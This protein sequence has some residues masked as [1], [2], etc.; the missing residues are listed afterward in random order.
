MIDLPY[1]TCK[2]AIFSTHRNAGRLRERLVELLVDQPW[3]QVVDPQ[4]VRGFVSGEIVLALCDREAD[5]EWPWLERLANV[6]E[7]LPLPP[8]LWEEDFTILA[9]WCLQFGKCHVERMSLRR[10]TSQFECRIKA[11]SG[12]MHM[13]DLLEEA[14]ERLREQTVTD[15]LTGIPNR[16]RFEEQFDYMWG[17]AV[18]ERIPIA[19]ILSDI[20]CFKN[21]NDRLGHQEGDRCLQAVATRL[22]DIV[23]GAEDLVARFG[24]EEFVVLLW[25][26]D[27]TKAGETAEKLRLGVRDLAIAHPGYGAGRVTISLGVACATP[28]LESSAEAFLFHADKLLYEAKAGGRDRWVQRPLVPPA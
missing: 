26:A 8:N 28:V 9:R 2:V 5:T 20:D 27:P 21:L 25:N 4:A 15:C 3:L 11:N 22:H 16:R 7:R 1:R 24:G 12:R 18:G 19:L 17:S 10:L 6:T 23:T 14:N 13:A